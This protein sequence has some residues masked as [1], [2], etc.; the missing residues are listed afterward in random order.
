MS[1]TLR[2][3]SR[4]SVT[5]LCTTSIRLKAALR[6]TTRARAAS[7]T[8][9]APRWT[10]ATRDAKL[11]QQPGVAVPCRPGRRA[12]GPA[13]LVEPVAFVPGL[14]VKQRTCQPRRQAEH[15]GGDVGAA[16]CRSGST[17]VAGA[18]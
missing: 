14:G 6:S 15:V 16:M 13:L 17:S 8:P 5:A 3:A 10:R 2:A 1:A 12:A 7:R 11:A 4:A 18:S 9:R